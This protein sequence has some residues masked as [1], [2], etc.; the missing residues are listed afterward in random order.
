MTDPVSANPVGGKADELR[1][2]FQKSIGST[3]FRQML[4]SL[5]QTTG[6]PAYLHG[7]QAEEMFQSQMDELLIDKLAETSGQSFADGLFE[8]QFPNLRPTQ[9]PANINESDA[10]RTHPGALIDEDA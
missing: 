2:V 7:G 8:Q 10:T 1:K 4:K 6:R 5:R 3:F 9:P